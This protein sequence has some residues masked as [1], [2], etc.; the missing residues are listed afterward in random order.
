MS[1]Y[2]AV[3]GS[4][5]STPKQGGTIDGLKHAHN[6]KISA[7][8]LEWVRRVPTNKQHLIN[9]RTFANE[10][11]ISLTVHAP[12]YV[13]LNAKEIDKLSASKKRVLDALSMAEIAGARSVCVHPAFYLGMDEKKVYENI[14]VA[15]EEI[16]NKK[17][18]FFPNVN[19]AFETMGKPSQFG[20]LEEVLRISK[21]F[22]IFPCVD[23]AHMHARTNGKWNSKEEWNTIFDLYSK[24]LGKESLKH[25][26]MHFSGIAYSEKGE[27]HHVPLLES[28]AKWIDFIR[29]LK[30]RNIGGTVVCESPLLEKDTLLMI[31]TFKNL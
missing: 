30:E 21:K 20:T 27:K 22:N 28:D 13:N 29:V 19:L 1:L 12:Y 23:P 17:D 16:M 18:K 4:P 11:K 10:L 24:Y 9:I 7:M 2:F 15:T 14:C 26:H 31:D 6:L 25:V 5:L 3:A 8:E